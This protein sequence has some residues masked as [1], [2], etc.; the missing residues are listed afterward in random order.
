MCSMSNR[1]FRSLVF[2]CVA[3]LFFGAYGGVIASPKIKTIGVVYSM[4]GRGD[5]G[6]ND[7]A[8]VGAQRAAADFG[9]KVLDIEP[10]QSSNVEP[11]IRALVDQGVELV[12]VVGFTS[13]E[14]VE[15][16]ARD[17]P[18]ARF[19]LI[20]GDVDSP[21]VACLKF[22]EHEGSFLV[23][24]VAGLTTKSNI[25][26]FVGGM[27][28]D[29]IRKFEVGYKE[30]VMYVNPKAKVLS[31]Y[32]GV[33][34]EAFRDPAKA[35]ELALAQYA[36]G[37]DIVFHASGPSGQGVIDAGKQ[38]KKYV[39]GVDT[40]QNWQ[41]PGIVLTSMLKHVENAVYDV[42]KSVVEGRFTGGVKLYGL[43]ENGVGIAID[44][45]NKS[46]LPQSTIDRVEQLKKDIVS[47]KIKVTDITAN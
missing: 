35:K 6:F 45:Y 26:G 8:Y 21:N 12:V 24:A 4:G 20:D 16:V 32:I 46:L 14:F 43:R 29:L 2:L 23:G 33:T 42:V 13:A 19:A 38:V 30:G 37:A 18:K 41:A 31:G 25:V 47:G 44:D 10:G 22:K 17:Y 36:Q 3:V 1:S 15:N 39:I 7:L 5:K 34:P 27:E 9:L 11:S 28:S 40:N